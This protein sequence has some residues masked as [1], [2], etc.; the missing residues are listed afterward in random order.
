[1]AREVIN[2]HSVFSFLGSYNSIFYCELV[3]T[4]RSIIFYNVVE[5][6]QQWIA[7]EL[8]KTSILETIALRKNKNF[9]LVEVNLVFKKLGDCGL[10]YFAGS[11]LMCQMFADTFFCLFSFSTWLFERERKKK[12]CRFILRFRTLGSGVKENN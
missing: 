3:P 8:S 7:L 9:V 5:Q 12:K 4:F 6:A 11:V 10:G 1:M 2:F